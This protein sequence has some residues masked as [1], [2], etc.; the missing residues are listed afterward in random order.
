VVELAS[1]RIVG[2]TGVDR[3]DFEGRTWLEWGY[4]LVPECRGLGYATEASR[5]LLDQAR[6][7]YTGE[8]LAIIA[9]ENLASQNVAR[10]L[11]FTFW[12]QAM[13]DGDL[14]NLSTLLI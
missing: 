7:T 12:K 8:L 10:K 4:R 3:I 5:A 11:A 2:Y 9:P 1:G 13:V 6:Q 14:R